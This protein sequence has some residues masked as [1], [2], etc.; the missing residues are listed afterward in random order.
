MKLKHFWKAA[1][2]FAAAALVLLP[3]RVSARELGSRE[4]YCYYED[5]TPSKVTTSRDF[6]TG[7]YAN[8]TPLLFVDG[9][10]YEDAEPYGVLDANDKHIYTKTITNNSS[11]NA[12]PSDYDQEYLENWVSVHTGGVDDT[13][14]GDAQLHVI[15]T[16]LYAVRVNNVKNAEVTIQN[17]RLN[18]YYIENANGNVNTIV[19]DGTTLSSIEFSSERDESVPVVVKGNI[20]LKLKDASSRYI[21][22]FGTVYGDTRIELQGSSVKQIQA[23]HNTGNGNSRGNVIFTAKNSKIGWLCGVGDDERGHGGTVNGDI[24][25]DLEQTTEADNSLFKVSGYTTYSEDNVTYTV[26]GKST[27]KL[28]DCVMDEICDT[29]DGESQNV[30]STT[31]VIYAKNVT[32]NDNYDGSCY[33]NDVH[34]SGNFVGNISANYVRFGNNAQITGTVEVLKQLSGK[35]EFLSYDDSIAFGQDAAIAK[36]TKIHIVPV[37][38]TTDGKYEPCKTSEQLLY[39]IGI[40]FFN[41]QDPDKY[42][43]YFT[44]DY[45]ELEPR[46]ATGFLDYSE[47]RVKNSKPCSS[48]GHKWKRAADSGWVDVERYAD[49][50][51]TAPTCTKSG[52]EVYYCTVCMAYDETLHEVKPLGHAYAASVTAPTTEKGGYTTY[53]CKR[54]KDSYKT[55]FT[56]PL[57]KN[58]T[59]DKDTEKKDD[60]TGNDTEKKDDVTGNDTEKKDD[61]TG[62]DT[63]KKD[64]VTGGDTEK[65]DD[66]TGNDTEKKDDVTGNDTEKKDDVTGG[67]TEKKDD[68]TGNDTEKKDDATGSDTEKKDDV[69]GNDTEKKDD[70]TSGNTGNTTNSTTISVNKLQIRMASTAVYSGKSLKPSVTVKNGKKTLKNGRDYKV[71]YKNNKNVGTAT[72]TITG[73]GSYKGSKKLTFKI[74]PKEAV[75][76]GVQSKTAKTV[77]VKWKRDSAVTGYVIQYSTDKNFKKDVKKVTVTKNK[78]S[79]ITLKKLKSKKNYYVRVAS[80]KKVNG[81]TYTGKYSDV[82]KI[83]VK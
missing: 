23:A 19:S 42:K 33:A 73:K 59:A 58:D 8:G 12:K 52:W 28:T 37:K 51:N 55:D 15:N 76:S 16:K 21:S 65:K 18:S 49:W 9:V 45:N 5:G 54:C 79:S 61:V 25:I 27:V 63:E 26:N 14:Y 68:V 11:A 83:K 46:Q 72:V 24:E 71:T 20:T 75:L 13:W 22:A 7:I 41:K 77:W 70:T 17:S 48:T 62:G 6:Y 32:L 1:A 34:I 67:D 57:P 66:V 81:K 4:Y 30:V 35:A 36:G 40:C 78:T 82:K 60:V 31:A 47:L 80:Y 3:A 74:L 64:D 2:C 44:C 39:R 10:M 56:D 43:S 69:T 53:T 38:K 50:N 29:C